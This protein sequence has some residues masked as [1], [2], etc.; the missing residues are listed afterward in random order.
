MRRR[1]TTLA[2]LLVT[3]TVLGVLTAIAAP[4][5]KVSSRAMV[6]QNARL[7]AQDLDLAR[8]RAY[9]TRARVRTLVADSTWRTFFDQNRDSV[10]SEST[11]EQT[12]YGVMSRRM[13]EPRVILSRGKAGPLP[14]DTVTATGTT[15]RIQFS[16]RGVAEPFGNTSVVYL[17][18]RTD[19]ASVYAVEVS[20]G[21]NIRVWRWLNNTWQ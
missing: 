8:T 11:A 19:S 12:A 16:P 5:M 18:H 14:S 2:E 4:R 21:A 7:L 10:F 6:E 13:L 20:P 1:G 17:T 15:R 3:M 9:S